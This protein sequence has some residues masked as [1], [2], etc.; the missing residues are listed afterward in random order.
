M[1]SA[2]LRRSRT[3]PL[4]RTQRRKTAPARRSKLYPRRS[5]GLM[6]GVH[7]LCPVGPLTSCLGD[8]LPPI[9]DRVGRSRPCRAPA[10][11]ALRLP[12]T[13]ARGTRSGQSRPCRPAAEQRPPARSH[14]GRGVPG[15]HVPAAQR[16]RVPARAAR[17]PR[18]P[19]VAAR[20]G[21]ERPPSRRGRRDR[22]GHG[23]RCKPVPAQGGGCG[24]RAEHVW[25]DLTVGRA[26]PITSRVP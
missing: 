10:R 15:R 6:P 7:L 22:R 9:R 1:A 21:G 23:A 13:S 16:R 3:V 19:K 26:S 4:R 25:A 11:A 24:P 20:A 5:P 18:G 12:H 2:E 17:P 8:G 14:E